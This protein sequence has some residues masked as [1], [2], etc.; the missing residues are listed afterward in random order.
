M[1][2]YLDDL[3]RAWA[4]GVSRRRAL[5]RFLGAAAGA[6]VATI[7]GLA[8]VGHAQKEF[9]IDGTV[10][11]G[12]RNGRRCRIGD[13]VTVLTDAL[14][15]GIKPVTV[16]ITWI[17][18]QLP[19]LDQD[20]PLCLTVQGLGDGSY[21]AVAVLD[22]C[23]LAGTFDRGR[24]TGSH[25]APEQPKR[26]DLDQEQIF[27]V[28]QTIIQ[29]NQTVLQGC[30]PATC[31]SLG[32]QCGTWPDGCGGALQCGSCPRGLDCNCNGTCDSPTQPT[33][34]DCGGAGCCRTE[35]CCPDSDV[36]C[37][38]GPCGSGEVSLNA[39]SFFCEEGCLIACSSD[40]QCPGTLDCLTG[41]AGGYSLAACCESFKV[42]DGPLALNGTV[43][44]DG[45]IP[46]S[47]CFQD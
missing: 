41:S 1:G 46:P 38:S 5:R 22:L 24:S 20:D 15:G 27:E 28:N 42:I 19:V 30:T 13:T 8:R 33:F 2:V 6:A 18:K 31:S 3:A 25:K 26:P 40:E 32:K 36:C 47:Q 34:I 4:S 16:D 11:C 12:Q 7:P 44:C 9:E 43:I 45:G 29:V 10:D 39:T 35:R 17:K 23:E 14:G 21:R 37:S